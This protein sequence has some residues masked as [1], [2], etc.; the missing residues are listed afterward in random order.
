MQLF[1]HHRIWRKYSTCF[2]QRSGAPLGR[3]LSHRWEALGL[4]RNTVKSNTKSKITKP[5]SDINKLSPASEHSCTIY[6]I[7]VDKHF[8]N[9]VKTSIFKSSPI[10]HFHIVNTLH[11]QRSQ[12]HTNPCL[13]QP[14]MLCRKSSTFAYILKITCQKCTGLKLSENIIL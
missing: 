5:K 7:Q 14:I 3:E 9:E 11:Q 1:S 2:T 12:E 4:N 10:M 13:P 8:R 6:N